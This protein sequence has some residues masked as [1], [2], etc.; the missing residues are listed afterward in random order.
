[1]TIQSEKR[2]F[3]HLTFLCQ[4]NFLLYSPLANANS[5]RADHEWEGQ[6]EAETA[7]HQVD[8][9]VQ[10]EGDVLRGRPRTDLGVGA[11]RRCRNH[12][13]LEW[14][15]EKKVSDV[16]KSADGALQFESTFEIGKAT[17]QGKTVNPTKEA[18]YV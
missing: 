4:T 1:M 16:Q 8:R 18:L 10:Q 7:E 5:E 14:K 17:L 2:N 13:K 6:E 3:P 12:R 9:K 15:K 11:G